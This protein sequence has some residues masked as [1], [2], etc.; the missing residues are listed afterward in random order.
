[1]NIDP[2]I[3]RLTLGDLLLAAMINSSENKQLKARVAELEKPAVAEP[4][5]EK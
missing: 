3:L 4:A 2:E 5:P 1:M